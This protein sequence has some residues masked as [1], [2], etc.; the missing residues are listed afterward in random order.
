MTMKDLVTFIVTLLCTWSSCQTEDPN[1]Y[2]TIQHLGAG[3]VQLGMIYMAEHDELS[4][5]NLYNKVPRRPE[6]FNSP[7]QI[8]TLLNKVP[9]Y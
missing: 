1:G 7:C 3:Q 9:G 4:A 2:R 5:Y 6:V 8:L